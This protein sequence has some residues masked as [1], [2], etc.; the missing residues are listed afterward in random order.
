[1]YNLLEYLPC[2]ENEYR[3]ENKQCIPLDNRCDA[4]PDCPDRT[5]EINCGKCHFIVFGDLDIV[6]SHYLRVNRGVV[7]DC[8]N[9]LREAEDCS[10]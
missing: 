8:V 4:I 7:I 2:T 6:T 3:C 10:C 9:C 5:D 1:M